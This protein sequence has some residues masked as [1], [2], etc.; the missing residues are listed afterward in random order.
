MFEF[1][2][3]ISGLGQIM[4]EY[5]KEEEEIRKQL[6]GALKIVE[7]NL[8]S[9][10]KEHIATDMYEPWALPLWYVRTG[11]MIDDEAIES[12]TK[13]LRL[14]FSY[15]PHWDFPEYTYSAKG[16]RVREKRGN[17]LIEVIQTNS[18]WTWQPK[19]DTQDRQIMPRPFWN[20]FVREAQNSLIMDGLITNL[21]GYTLI[22]DGNDVLLDGNEFLA[23]G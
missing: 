16:E 8:R 9:S 13:G 1:N 10:L 20:N 19:E 21:S 5:A 12:S 17:E 3:E 4:Q 22:P 15:E 7:S 2:V 23:E 11:G 18:G 14:D 6:S